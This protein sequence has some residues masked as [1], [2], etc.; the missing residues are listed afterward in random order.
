MILA[1][2]SPFKGPYSRTNYDLSKAMIGRDG[3]NPKPTIYCSLYQNNDPG[4]PLCHLKEWG[5]LL[6][7]HTFSYNET[8]DNCT[9]N[10][11]RASLNYLAI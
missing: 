3:R 10:S 4:E 9:V 6:T 11:N 7:L 5:N 2:A 1:W 8:P